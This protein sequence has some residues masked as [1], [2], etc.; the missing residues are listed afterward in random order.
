MIKHQFL[1]EF[2]CNEKIEDLLVY[3]VIMEIIKQQTTGLSWF[4]PGH[5]EIQNFT[6]RECCKHD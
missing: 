4:I 1:V 2:E 5:I 6:I 3:F